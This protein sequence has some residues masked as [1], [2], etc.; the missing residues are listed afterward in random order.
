[1]LTEALLKISLSVIGRCSLVP[2]SQWLQGKCV[3][4]NLSRAASGMILHNH[5]RLPVSTFSVKIA[6]LW[7]LKRF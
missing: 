4:I 6:A 7:C 5:W 2:T 3:R 1:M